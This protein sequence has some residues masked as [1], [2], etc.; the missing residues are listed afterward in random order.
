[1]RQ[2]TRKHPVPPLRRHRQAAVIE[3]LIVMALCL[4]VAVLIARKMEPV[5]QIDESKLLT[6]PVHVITIP[7]EP[8]PEDDEMWVRYPVPLD[9]E[10]QRHIERLCEG[11]DISPAVVLAIIAVESEFDPE[12]VGDDG[13]SFGLM[14]IYKAYHEGR[15]EE[16][17]VTDLLD[18]YQNITVGIDILK[19]Y[20]AHYRLPL[21]WVLMAYNGGP[22]YAKSLYFAGTISNYAERVLALAEIY[23]EESMVE[24]S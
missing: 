19:E 16:L 7:P 15:M 23:D 9:D 4:L 21:E 6:G 14:Q 8:T 17:G 22:E 18:P 5:Y 12:K 10:L 20:Q 1:M 3:V 13:N 2:T 24:M 11:S